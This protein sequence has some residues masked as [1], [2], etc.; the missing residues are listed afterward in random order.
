[1]MKLN[2]FA[3]PATLT[4]DKEDGGFVV[5]F[6]DLPEAITQGETVQHCLSE[7]SDC[8]GE[9][10]AARI[11]DNMDI[12][13]PTQGR[14]KEHLVP[15]PLEIAWKAEI[16][17][18]MVHANISISRLASQLHVDKDRVRRLLN[19]RYGVDQLLA[20]FALHAI[21]NSAQPTFDLTQTETWQLCGSVEI[22]DPSSH[23]IV[24]YDE[25]GKAIANFAQQVDEVQY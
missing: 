3:F 14:E 10:I 22:P 24:G 13:L 12:P 25:Q 1:M 6:R 16:H 15:V 4:P 19:P 20:D 21:F 9:A 8:L 2:L 7:A 23:E 5:T 11:D 18:A 17:N